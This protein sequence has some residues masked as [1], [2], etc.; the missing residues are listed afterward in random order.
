MTYPPGGYGQQQPESGQ[1]YGQYGNQSGYPQSGAHN[2]GPQA[3]PAPGSDQYGQ[4]QQ[5]GGQEY[6]GQQGYGQQYGQAAQSYGQGQPGYG[7]STGPGYGQQG[8]QGYGQPGYGQQGQQGYGQYGYSPQPA[9][10]PSQGLPAITPV[11][12]AAAIGAFG[13]IVLFSGFLSAAETYD[14]ALK[15]FQTQYNAPYT[16]I[17]VAGIL[18]LISLIP[19]IK[20]PAAPI[21]ASL[22]ITS[23][24][25]TLFQFLN[26][27]DNGAGAI[28]LLIF[29]LLSAV[30][31]VVWLLTDAGVIKVAPAVGD[32][33]AAVTPGSS[34][35]TQSD[36]GAHQQTSGYGDAQTTAYGTGS[37]Q[38][39]YG[40]QASANYD[41]SAYS[42]SSGASATGQ[43]GYS[44][45][46]S[47]SSASA[48]G[49][50]SGHGESGY[51]DYRPGQYGSGASGA[52]PATPGASGTDTP[53]GDHSTTVFQ[54]PEPPTGSGN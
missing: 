33:T 17:S 44:G 7:Q 32:A 43:S 26:I 20:V 45:G 40:Q 25:I 39:Q 19:G 51:G 24:L 46:A 48:A 38:A 42:Q 22:A 14:F 5:Y 11:L 21:V 31:A 54:K 35:A 27:D 13:L 15:L 1:S 8:Q 16:L 53:A 34:A 41:P 49:S 23:F 36:A 18:A 6:G 50:A 9:K 3:S 52:S 30:L 47:D 2:T 29:T 37:A 28:V 12:L 10:Q 4:A